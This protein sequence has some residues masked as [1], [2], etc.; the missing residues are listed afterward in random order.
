MP[1]R[2]KKLIGMF[3]LVALVIIYALVASIFVVA[4]LSESGPLVQFLFFLFSGLL[5]V[6]PAM[7]IIKWLMLEPRVKR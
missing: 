3:L 1:I 6:L 4:R 5:W 7:G 2:L